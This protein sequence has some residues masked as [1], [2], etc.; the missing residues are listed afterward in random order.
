[1]G[2]NMNEKLL[3]KYANLAVVKGVNIQKGQLLK[4]TCP[5]ENADFGRL[6]VQAAYDNGA[7]KVIINYVDEL[8]TKIEFESASTETLCEFPEYKAKEM[9]YFIDN[10]YAVLNIY[11][12]TPGL[13]KNI[14]SDKM[15]EVMISRSKA[16]KPL[17]DYSMSNKGQWS[18]V[19][20]PTIGW[21]KTIFPELDDETAVEKLWETILFC[22][23]VDEE[24]DPNKNWDKHNK[25]MVNH[26]NIMNDYNFDYLTFKNS[27]GTDLKVHLATN[28][29]WAGG[30]EETTNGV[31]FNPNIPTEECFCMP[32]K[33][34]VFGK[35]V[36]TKPLNYQGKLI[37][38]FFMVFEDGKVVEYDAKKEKDAL[39]NLIEFD[40]GSAYLGE[41]A[42][43]SHDSP[44]SNSGILF[45]N[46]LFDENASCHLALGNAYPMNIKG[47]TE[48]KEEELFELG[49]NKSMV[50]EDFMFGSSDMEIKG[51]TFDGKE[52]TIF[53]DGNFVF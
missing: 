13:L 15:Q 2:Y 23:R 11:A 3:K 34:K 9:E 27:L 12:E 32:F 26:N 18:I 41:V 5:I 29:N 49:Y 25:S 8:T 39:K 17:R 36:S 44:I 45:Y 31:V 1:M 16:M 14:D 51:Y 43:I 20:V 7:R 4:I 48:M 52:V 50:H 22:C 46:T 53:K 37:E 24:T 28:H 21:A 35:V 40:D 19:S 30:C 10:N 38:D 47:G 42:L 6:C 33:T